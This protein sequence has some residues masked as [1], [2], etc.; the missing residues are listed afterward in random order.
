[1]ALYFRHLAGFWRPTYVITAVASLYL[2]V[3]VLIVQAFLKVPALKESAPTQTEAPF[4][5]TQLVT[6]VMFV[7]LGAMATIRFRENKSV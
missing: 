3:F 5:V 7:I 2:N 1:M 6:L 4:A